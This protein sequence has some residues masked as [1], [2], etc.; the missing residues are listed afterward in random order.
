[1]DDGV[2]AGLSLVLR[3]PFTGVGDVGGDLCL[4]LGQAG[5]FGF[6]AQFVQEVDAQALAVE[7][8]GEVEKVGFQFLRGQ[9][10]HGGILTEAG[11]A[12]AG[13]ECAVGG[14]DEYAAEGVAVRGEVEVGGGAADGA[15]ELGAVF[16]AA[17]EGIVVAEQAGGVAEAAFAEGLAHEGAAGAHVLHHYGGGALGGEFGAAAEEAEV[18]L[19]ACAESEVVADEQ[20][21]GAQLFDEQVLDEVGG[22]YG[23]EVGVETQYPD[24]IEAAGVAQQAQFFAQGAEAEGFFRT[25]LPAEKFLRLGL[26]YDGHGS[27]AALVGFMAQAFEDVAVAEVD[28]VEIADGN[29]AAVRVRAEYGV[30]EADVH[31]GRG[32]K[33]GLL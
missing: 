28:A 6:V 15:A 12:V 23:G 9:A 33:K 3:Q 21:A 14:D 2:M 26:E 5:E 13:A 24:G 1:M 30:A 11:H 7:I 10:G 29:G 25:A 17:A 20:V 22:G 19:A 16:H 31:G 27:E 32:G 4:Q 8:V 18:A